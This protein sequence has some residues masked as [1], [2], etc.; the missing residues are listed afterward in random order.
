MS[1][2]DYRSFFASVKHFVKINYFLKLE[3]INQSQF[4]RFMKGDLF[5][6]EMSLDSLDRL[7]SSVILELGKIT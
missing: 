7:Y 4:S 1:K 2:G 5:D 3:N 6:Y